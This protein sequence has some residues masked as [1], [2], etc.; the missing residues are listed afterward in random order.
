MAHNIQILESGNACFVEATHYGEIKPAWHGL[1]TQ[2]DDP[3]TLEE[4]TKYIDNPLEI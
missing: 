4:L 3:M 1:G 2:Y